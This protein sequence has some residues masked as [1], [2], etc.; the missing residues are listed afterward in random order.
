VSSE[1]IEKIV[2]IGGGIFGALAGAAKLAVAFESPSKSSHYL[3]SL[4]S[5]TWVELL[6]A[7]IVFAMYWGVRMW[8]RILPQRGQK[9]AWSGFLNVQ[10]AVPFAVGFLLLCNLAGPVYYFADERWTYWSQMARASYAD[11][12]K[13]R[14]DDLAAKGRIEDAHQLAATV[15]AALG[16]HPER[17]DIQ[18]RLNVLS[19]ATARSKELTQK[20]RETWNSVT[21]RA[22]YFRLVEA[23]RIDPQNYS[24][25]AEVKLMKQNVEQRIKNDLKNICSGN[26]LEN[27]RGWTL[28]LLEAKIMLAE[29]ESSDH[30]ME[31]EAYLRN[32]WGFD[33]VDCILKYSDSTRA[34]SRSRS[35]SQ[36]KPCPAGPDFWSVPAK[37]DSDD[38]ERRA[39][40]TA[41]DPVPYP[42]LLYF[43]RR[44]AM[45]VRKRL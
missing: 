27:F 21:D 2:K 30:C 36:V 9:L 39:S 22:A 6:F 14:I 44:A 19:R 18:A 17:H 34:T 16:D 10:R 26:G 25:S 11:S 15:F 24:A 42:S 33:G 45:F 41:K 29:S 23:V 7:A 37:T 3:V 5:Q 20:S 28:S 12:Y 40:H 38:D 35:D 8:K 43:A 32:S 13:V 31:N 4:A 1:K